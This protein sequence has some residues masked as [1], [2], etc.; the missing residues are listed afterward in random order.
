MAGV[1]VVEHGVGDLLCDLA[2][3]DADA[4]AQV[5]YA[6]VENVPGQ[7]DAK[8]SASPAGVNR[9]KSASG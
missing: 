6:S 8:S 1:S 2:D 3:E 7:R 9:Q 5:P 4:G